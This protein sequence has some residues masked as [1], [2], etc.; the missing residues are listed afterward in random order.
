M[1]TSAEL[2]GD[3]PDMGKGF[4]AQDQAAARGFCHGP[5]RHIV[6]RRA[7]P[8]GNDDRI[9]HPG[10]GYDCIRDIMLPIADGQVT[11][12]PDAAPVKPFRNP[13]GIRVHHFSQE[14]FIAD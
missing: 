11:I 5:G 6:D 2:P 14:Q 13:G 8:P 10:K 4:L 3:L 7:K 9:G 1:D 12:H